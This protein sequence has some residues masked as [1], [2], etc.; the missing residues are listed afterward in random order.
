MI[1]IY[2]IFYGGLLLGFWLVYDFVCW[3]YADKIEQYKMYREAEKMYKNLKKS[4]I[5]YNIEKE[6]KILEQKALKRSQT[7][8]F[9]VQKAQGKEVAIF[10]DT[11]RAW[12]VEGRDC[13]EVDFEEIE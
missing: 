6:K 7:A 1:L 3:R 11:R 8:L 9:D 5:A 2:S 10:K 4:L 13:V 12:I